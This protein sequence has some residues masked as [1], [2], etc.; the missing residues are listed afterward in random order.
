MTYM[1]TV[2]AIKAAAE[3][4]DIVYADEVVAA[5][6]AA[7]GGA[8]VITTGALTPVPVTVRVAMLVFMFAQSLPAAVANGPLSAV[9]AVVH[10]D[11][12]AESK[13]AGVARLPEEAPPEVVVTVTTAFTSIDANLLFGAD[14]DSSLR[15]EPPAATQLYT[16]EAVL[17]PPAAVVMRASK[18]VW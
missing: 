15:E 12:N 7:P 4:M 10:A 17:S 16:P 6:G 11:C 3:N 2:A 8:V 13:A 5:G 18:A 9:A 1:K 14:L